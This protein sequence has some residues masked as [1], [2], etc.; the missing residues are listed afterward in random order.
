MA[1]PEQEAEGDV[2]RIALEVPL[3]YVHLGTVEERE[4]PD[5]VL[6]GIGIDA[7]CPSLSTYLQSEK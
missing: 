5:E 4:Q 2:G 1:E 7:I 3:Q 6:V